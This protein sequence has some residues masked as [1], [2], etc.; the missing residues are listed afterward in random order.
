VVT[1]V[2]LMVSGSVQVAGAI[3]SVNL[4]GSGFSL[5][6]LCAINRMLE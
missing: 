5:D 2:Q 1:E 4:F 6:S 3:Q